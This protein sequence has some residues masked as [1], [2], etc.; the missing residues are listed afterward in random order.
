MQ[1][2][3]RLAKACSGLANPNATVTPKVMAR[4]IPKVTSFGCDVIM[5]MNLVLSD[6]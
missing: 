6:M 4:L 3:Q 5:F 1:L 2:L